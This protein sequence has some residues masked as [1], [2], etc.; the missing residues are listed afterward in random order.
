MKEMCCDVLMV[1]N[2]AI[3]RNVFVGYKKKE[4]NNLLP[5]GS[6]NHVTVSAPP[7]WLRSLPSPSYTCPSLLLV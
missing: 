4:K 1:S 6:L 5:V 7:V 2:K 3:K